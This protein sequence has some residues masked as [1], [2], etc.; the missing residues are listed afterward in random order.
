MTWLE[1][2][3]FL[4][5]KVFLI[6]LTF[7]DPDEKFIEQYQTSGAVDELTDDGTFKFKRSDG[8]IFLLPYAK[9]TIKPAA[10]GKYHVT[11]IDHTIT[12]P[13]YITAWE[14]KVKSLE[15]IPKIKSVGFSKRTTL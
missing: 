3:T 7:I 2:Q 5:G 4:K 13:D 11:E 12:E 1:L 6:G 8:S 9:E 14:I 10:K 15:N